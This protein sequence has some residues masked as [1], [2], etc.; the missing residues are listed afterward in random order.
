MEIGQKLRVTTRKA[1]RAWLEKNHARKKEIWLVYA[2]K[3]SGRGRVDY[4]DAVEEALCFGWIDGTMKSIDENYFAQRFSPRRS[5]KS[6]LS[7]TNKERVRRM[8]RAGL[9]TP[10]GLE[11]IRDRMAEKFALAPDIVAALKRDPQSWKN[12]QRFPKWYQRV[13]VGWLDA[14]RH[15]QDIFESRLRYF[16][17]MTAQNKRYGQVHDTKERRFTNRRRRSVA[18]GRKNGGL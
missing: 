8:I 1:W 12:F 4:S 17:K 16:I 15:R 3:K 14:S 9:M 13:R 2:K 7:E 5:S 18:A 6:Q 10:A 11:K